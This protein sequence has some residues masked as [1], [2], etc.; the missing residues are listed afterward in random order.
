MCVCVYIYIPHRRVFSALTLCVFNKVVRNG[1][2]CVCVCVL[3]TVKH[4]KTNCLSSS[5]PLSSTQAE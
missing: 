1:T 4:H 2:V 3:I 5:F